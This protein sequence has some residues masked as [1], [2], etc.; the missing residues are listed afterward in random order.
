MSKR[1]VSKKTGLETI[2]TEEEYA[3]VLRKGV[4]PLNRFVIT[5]LNV[6]SI[7]PSLTEVKEV[8]ITKK[9]NK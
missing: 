1:L 6:R 9:S 5:D 3:S 4:I 2:L 7:I 8:K